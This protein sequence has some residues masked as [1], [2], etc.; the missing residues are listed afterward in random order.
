MRWYAQSAKLG[1]LPRLAYSSPARNIP[2]AL[3]R[4]P[5]FR[6]SP[7]PRI[8]DPLR[9]FNGIGFSFPRSVAK[10]QVLE[11]LERRA[12]FLLLLKRVGFLARFL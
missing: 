6:V 10:D 4:Q 11:V 9:A 3:N 2:A 1:L 5:K 12:Q 8:L 7:H